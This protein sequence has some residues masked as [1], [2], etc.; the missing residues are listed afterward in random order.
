V[1]FKIIDI[2]KTERYSLVQYTDLKGDKMKKISILLVVILLIISGCSNSKTENDENKGLDISNFQSGI[3][4]IDDTSTF[5]KQ[6]FSYDITISNPEKMKVNEDSIKIVLTDWIK[7]KQIENKITKLS[8]DTEGIVIKG[9]I[10]FDSKGLDKKEIVIHQPFIDGI[11]VV[12]D[13]G[14]EIFIKSHFH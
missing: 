3:G 2:K 1:L 14:E 6:K 7:G 5:D 8:F 10:I 12:T 4:A 11:S 9:Y 13:E